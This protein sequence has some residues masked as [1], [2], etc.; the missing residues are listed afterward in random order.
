VRGRE[1]LRSSYSGIRKHV[2]LRLAGRELLALGV[3]YV[4]KMSG[5]R[6]DILLSG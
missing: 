2:P 6:T 3:N 1:I 5:C 4:I